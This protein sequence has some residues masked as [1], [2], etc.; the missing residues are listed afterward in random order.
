MKKTI[1]RL[2]FL[3]AICAM[4]ALQGCSKFLDTCLDTNRTSET[5]KT[6]RSSIW[7]FANAFYTPINYGYSVIDN[8]LFA[9]ASDE[10]QQTSAASDVIYF[11]NGMNN[12]KVTL[13][14]M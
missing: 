3:T 7:Y 4:T 14:S 2:S 9:S 13:L 10:A 6:D 12:Q 8:N 5:I 11:N 1:I